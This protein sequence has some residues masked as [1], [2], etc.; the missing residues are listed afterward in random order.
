MSEGLQPAQPGM[1][2]RIGS[3]AVFVPTCTSRDVYVMFDILANS[4]YR[5]AVTGIL[6]RSFLLGASRL[7]VNGL[8][9]FLKLLDERA[10]IDGRE[11]GLLTGVFPCDFRETPGKIDLN[12]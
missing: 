4:F 7:E 10:D 2:W 12:W 6:S 1:L 9:N 3:A 5:F 8:D 11:R